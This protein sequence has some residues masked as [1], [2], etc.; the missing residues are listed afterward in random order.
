[1]EEYGAGELVSATNIHDALTRGA[2]DV[3]ANCWLWN[4]GTIPEASIFWIPMMYENAGQE[5]AVYW[6]VQRP[7]ADKIY[8]EKFNQTIQS[9]L[10]NAPQI[11]WTKKPVQKM[12]DYKGMKVRA[13]GGIT[14]KFFEL[15]GAS[16]V[17]MTAPE[18][19]TALQSGALDGI[20]YSTGTVI[21]YKLT[22]TTPNCILPGPQWAHVEIHWN[23]NVW[24]SL[25]PDI[26]KTIE[27][28][29]RYVNYHSGTVK[30]PQVD[31]DWTT[32]VE[33]MGAKFYRLP[34]AETARFK[35]KAVESWD[36]YAQQSADCRRLLEE[37]KKFLEIK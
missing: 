1:M 3:A 32:T 6:E 11:M 35:A 5:A 36:W 30:M 19:L 14:T 28:Y 23:L 10:Y 22:E 34:P 7:I 24:N 31:A 8:R 4:T 13:P 29:S 20:T 33:K 27:E 26:Q 17:S 16:V 25:P 9:I 21:A 15:L 18:A 2:L 12:E 37:T